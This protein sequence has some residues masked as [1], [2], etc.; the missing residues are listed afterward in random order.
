MMR[1]RTNR[2]M[3]AYLNE[4]N[5]DFETSTYPITEELSNIIQADFID[6]NDSITLK[7]IAGHIQNPLFK[8]SLEKSEWEYNETHFHPD[9]S[10]MGYKEEEKEYLKAALECGKQL[11]WR[12]RDCYPDKHFRVVISFC[13]T[14]YDGKAV[15]FY[16]SSTVRFYQIR[17]EVETI[18][19]IDDLNYYQ[20]DAVMDIEF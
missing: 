8:T 6:N 1:I 15:D 18:M 14:T 4:L 12:L 13:E 10:V 5:F 20:A 3:D 11:V 9:W 16:G 17:P 7:S 19:R 2:I